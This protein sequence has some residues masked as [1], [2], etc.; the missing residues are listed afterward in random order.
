MKKSETLIARRCW[1]G[2]TWSGAGVTISRNHIAPI[3]PISSSSQQSI[4]L[5]TEIPVFPNNDVI[6]HSDLDRAGGFD[7]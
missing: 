6:Q 7:H 1:V 5:K 4:F 3:G 2:Q